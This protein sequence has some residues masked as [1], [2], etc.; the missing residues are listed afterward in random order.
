MRHKIVYDDQVEYA[1][2]LGSLYPLIK[3]KHKLTEI[4]KIVCRFSKDSS[5][6][7]ARE[8]ALNV[9]KTFVTE[10]YTQNNALE[11]ITTIASTRARC[12]KDED[13]RKV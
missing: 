11:T 8:D 7:Q 9:L 5:D 6:D 13:I 2:G 1:N 4:F 12:D 3:A 10:G